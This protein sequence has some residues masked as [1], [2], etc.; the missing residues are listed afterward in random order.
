MNKGGRGSKDHT[1]MRAIHALVALP[2]LLAVPAFAQDRSVQVVNNSGF[3]IVEFYASTQGAAD[4]QENM[5]AGQAV[6]SGANLTV[7]F[8]DGS[9]E[10]AYAFRAVF[11]DGDE[12]VGDIDICS[13]S[14][15]TIN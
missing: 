4:W 11:D 13:G 10:C 3:T 9:G 6:G 1:S 15:I 2:L 7:N 14:S 12:A 8:D 5:L